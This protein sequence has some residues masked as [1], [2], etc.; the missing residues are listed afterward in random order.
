[1]VGAAR[2]QPRLGGRREVGPGL[3]HRACDGQVRQLLVRRDDV[4]HVGREAEP[5][6]H[7]GERHDD[8]RSGVG[9][10]DQADRV[11][12]ATDAERV[13]LESRPRG[14]Q[15]RADLEH[16]SAEDLLVARYQVVG[17][18]LHE[19]G[20]ARQACAHDLGGS[21]EHGRLPVTLGAEAEALRHQ[22]LDREPRELTQRAEVLEVGRERRRAE[23][24]EEP[25]ERE[26]LTRAVAQRLVP[27][28][29]LAQL[30]SDVV[31]V[32]VLGD[33]RVDVLLRHVG[34]GRDEVVDPPGVHRDAEPELGLGLVALGHRDVA[35]VVTETRELELV[36]RRPA[37]SR[38]HPGSDGCRHGGVRHVADNRL[39]RHAEAGLDVAE[40][41]VAVRRLVQVHEVHVDRRPRQLDVRLGVQVQQRRA[42]SVQAGDPH[43][44]R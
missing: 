25:E 42:E 27:F 37:R 44:G 12:L 29:V 24:A 14:R 20:A 10:E 22:P 15:G 4:D 35:H 3:P 1:M 17:V 21:D 30:G 11:L 5:V 32:L 34:D 38:T 7:V 9:V 8:T 40:L 6:A 26:L 39:A 36:G 43:L 33:E 13:H 41:A 2:R 19:R 31:E 23:V 18:V 16:V 28:A